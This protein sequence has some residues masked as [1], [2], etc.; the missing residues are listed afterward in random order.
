MQ[1]ILEYLIIIL[2]T[3]ALIWLGITY[4]RLKAGLQERARALYEH[5]RDRDLSAITSS[6]ET[7]SSDT[8][9]R[10][11]E[12]RSREW[13]H[14]EE[15]KI[16]QDAIR[17][18]REVIHGK[19]TEHL[20]PFFPSFPWNPADARFLGSPID[21]V[22]FDG[23]SEGMVREVILVEVKSGAR[24][25]LSSRERSV[26]QCIRRGAVSFRIIHPDDR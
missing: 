16:R 24:R 17:R 23:L 19:V 18:S 21:F 26:E 13:K 2:L 15:E 25:V 12:L 5:W 20:I 22:V 10:E 8:I 6:M 11:V 4:F 9:N 14:Q 1:M 3:I 7:R